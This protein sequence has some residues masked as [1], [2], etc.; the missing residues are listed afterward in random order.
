MKTLFKLKK[1]IKNQNL[2]AYIVPKN[3]EF[4]G[5]YAFRNRLKAVSNFS[6]S[7][8]FAIITLKLNY[9]FID[10]RYLIQSKMESGK[11]YKIIEIPYTYPKNILNSNRINKIGYDPKLFTVST[12]RRYFG[13][14][15]QLISIKRNLIDLIYFEKKKEKSFFFTMHDK[16]VGES[17]SSK[18]NRLHKIVIK[19][20]TDNIF[21][22]APENVAWLLNIRGKDNPNSPIPNS[23]L[24]MDKD[25]KIYFFSDLK[26][27]KAIKKKNKI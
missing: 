4:F 1:L 3:D 16:T 2:D 12:L 17:V 26:K 22:S 7:A 24:I 18:I 9:L 20:N 14:K 25:K 10:G 15:F 5:E 13:S 23:R 8:G 21:V 6:G 11:K 27:I 19:K